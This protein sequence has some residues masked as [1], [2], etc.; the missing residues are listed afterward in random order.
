MDDAQGT[1]KHVD[2]FVLA[3][4]PPRQAMRWYLSSTLNGIKRELQ[5]VLGRVEA[6]DDVRNEG[7]VQIV[8]NLIDQIRDALTDY[9]VSLDPKRFL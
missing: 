3:T 2:P 6:T 4:W 7:D 8:S 1:A 5:A 9:Q